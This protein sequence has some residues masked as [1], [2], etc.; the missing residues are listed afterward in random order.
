MELY[1]L[2]SLLVPLFTVCTVRSY[3]QIVDSSEFGSFILPGSLLIHFLFKISGAR[4]MK[5]PFK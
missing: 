2:F 1:E 5:D 3:R 4:N